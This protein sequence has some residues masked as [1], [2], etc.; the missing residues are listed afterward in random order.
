MKLVE[1]CNISTV[2]PTTVRL[3]HVAFYTSLEPRICQLSERVFCVWS[4]ME[5]MMVS[6]F[7]GVVQ[8]VNNKVKYS[9]HDSLLLSPA[10]HCLQ[11][12]LSQRCVQ[13]QCSH[14][15]VIS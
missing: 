7:W 4:F 11:F 14:L 13:E 6:C 10:G 15:S 8:L 9:S 1:T 2:H 12:A 3:L 5:L